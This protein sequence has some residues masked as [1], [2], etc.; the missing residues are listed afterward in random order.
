MNVHSGKNVNSMHPISTKSSID[1]RNN[2]GRPQISGIHYNH[3]SQANMQSC[4]SNSLQD[5]DLKNAMQTSQKR[6][7][8]KIPRNSI[9]TKQDLLG[10]GMDNKTSTRNVKDIDAGRGTITSIQITELSHTRR[11]DSGIKQ[12]ETS[13]S[14]I[15][16]RIMTPKMINM[17]YDPFLKPNKPRKRTKNSKSIANGVSRGFL[18]GSDSSN[19]PAK[20]NLKKIL[21]TS[22]SLAQRKSRHKSSDQPNKLLKKSMQIRKMQMNIHQPGGTIQNNYSTMQLTENGQFVAINQVL[23]GQEDS[24]R[25]IQVDKSSVEADGNSTAQEADKT[26]LIV[27]L[28]QDGNSFDSR[29]KSPPTE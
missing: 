16:Q 24:L 20:A 27:A 28:T 1:Q 9:P 10:I 25:L 26:A 8:P 23:K 4:S 18:P 19:F 3:G 14:G 6:L 22:S 7:K 11:K 12:K 13:Q 21:N 15:G 17:S 29:G 2:L 5:D